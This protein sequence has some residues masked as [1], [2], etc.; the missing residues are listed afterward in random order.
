MVS[1]ADQIAELR[2]EVAMRRNVYPKRIGGGAMTQDDAD[3][4]IGAIEAAIATLR[5]IEQHRDGLRALVVELRQ[6]P[7]SPDAT[8]ARRSALMADPIVAAVVEAFP[9]SRILGEDVT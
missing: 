6:A 4:K 3:R 7:G 8:S 1:L 2:R 5:F 9:G